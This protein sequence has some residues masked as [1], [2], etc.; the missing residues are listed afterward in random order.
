[1]SHC[2]VLTYHYK[3]PVPSYFVILPVGKGHFKEQLAKIKI[4]TDIRG[5]DVTDHEH[6][7]VAAAVCQNRE[8][9]PL[10]FRMHCD[11]RYRGTVTDTDTNSDSNWG[12]R[13]GGCGCGV[14]AIS[15]R[16]VFGYDLRFRS[17][18]LRFRSD[19]IASHPIRSVPILPY[20]SGWIVDFLS[21][22]NKTKRSVGSQCMP[23]TVTL[24]TWCSSSG[25]RL[26]C[27]FPQLVRARE[28]QGFLIP[29]IIKVPKRDL[30]RADRLYHRRLV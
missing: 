22:K 18:A 7:S 24:Q 29:G 14:S 16:A 27:W 1:V 6:L 26:F 10:P 11:C 8:A 21:A 28:T 30:C 9:L 12:S 3:W 13:G 4:E 2:Y 23:D 15:L 20:Q 5:C 19:P 25:F 17:A